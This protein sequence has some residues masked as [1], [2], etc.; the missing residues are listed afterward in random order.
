M[1]SNWRV[2]SIQPD[3]TV[4]AADAKSGKALLLTLSSISGRR[5]LSSIEWQK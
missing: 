3:K 1:L 2:Y 4:V 5:R